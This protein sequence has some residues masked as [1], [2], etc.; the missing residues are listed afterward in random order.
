VSVGSSGKRR[1]L[2]ERTID[3]R[4]GEVERRAAGSSDDDDLK[5]RISALQVRSLRADRDDLPRL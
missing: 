1:Q 4:Q 2:D 3:R 5:R